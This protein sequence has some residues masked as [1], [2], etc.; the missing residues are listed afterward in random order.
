MFA[1]GSRLNT[2]FPSDSAVVEVVEPL[3]RQSF[4]GRSRPLGV[5]HEP[6]RFSNC[7]HKTE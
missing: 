6:D 2:W 1:M 4:A 5:G 3:N 7:G